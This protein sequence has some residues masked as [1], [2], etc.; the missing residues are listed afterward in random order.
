MI[1]MLGMVFLSIQTVAG[2]GEKEVWSL[3]L[4]F[5]RSS[6]IF[7]HLLKQKILESILYCHKHRYNQ[8][9]IIV[10]L[11]GVKSYS[12]IFLRWLP[13][14]IAIHSCQQTNLNL[15]N[16]HQ[17]QTIIHPRRVMAVSKNPSTSHNFGC[18]YTCLLYKARHTSIFQPSNEVYYDKLYNTKSV[19][20]QLLYYT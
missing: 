19:L 17:L 8:H 12:L 16:L 18:T 9:Q 20:S 15:E 1:R 2:N 7:S 6:L 10:W 14:W 11:E 13:A 3:Y 5:V 4:I